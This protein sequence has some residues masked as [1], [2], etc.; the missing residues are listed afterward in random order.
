MFCVI[1]INAA[2][3]VAAAFSLYIYFTAASPKVLRVISRVLFALSAAGLAALVIISIPKLISEGTSG[4]FSLLL[5]LEAAA[6]IICL[7][8]LILSYVISRGERS[9]ALRLAAS[10]LW[11]MI[12]I[13]CSYSV[14]AIINYGKTE[15]LYIIAGVFCAMILSLPV[16]LDF[17]RLSQ[18]LESDKDLANK[19]SASAAVRKAHRQQ[20][21]NIAEKKK[22]L[23][24]GGKASKK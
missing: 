8:I 9:A 13:I 24:R 12:I 17:L 10:P 4:D 20:R 3:L 21:K 18:K 15:A 14:S 2:I 6:V 19:R 22:R 11:A 1:I 23:R 16:A 5:R 7:T